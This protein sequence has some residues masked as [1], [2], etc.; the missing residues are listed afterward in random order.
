MSI[1]P[2]DEKVAPTVANRKS[3]RRLRPVSSSYPAWLHQRH[4][5]EGP[6]YDRFL[7][8]ITYTYLL[9]Q[10]N[11]EGRAHSSYQWSKLGTTPGIYLK[12]ARNRLYV[13]WYLNLVPW[14][15]GSLTFDGSRYALKKFHVIDKH[16]RTFRKC[17]DVIFLEILWCN[18][19]KL[20]NLWFNVIF[21]IKWRV[22]G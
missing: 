22:A 2:R 9:I 16:T 18:V 17:Y 1:I 13:S 21:T 15:Y 10:R 14:L 8:T 3:P 4:G 7:N 12:R 6:I 20:F 19:S 5:S 11:I